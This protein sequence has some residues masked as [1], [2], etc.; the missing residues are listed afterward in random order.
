ML[1]GNRCFVDRKKVLFC[2]ATC[3]NSPDVVDVVK[4]ID[5]LLKWVS[6]NVSLESKTA[7]CDYTGS[8]GTEPL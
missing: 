3:H 1:I 8:Q 2:Y 5:L 6:G 7:H 4:C